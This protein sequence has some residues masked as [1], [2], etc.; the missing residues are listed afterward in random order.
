[1]YKLPPIMHGAAASVVQKI[2]ASSLYKSAT[3]CN[4]DVLH[5]GVVTRAYFIIAEVMV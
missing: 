3:A 4:H 1:V 2:R 5:A